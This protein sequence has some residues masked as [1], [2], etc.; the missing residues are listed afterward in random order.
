MHSSNMFWFAEYAETD[1]WWAEFARAGSEW[2]SE[3][4]RAGPLAGGAS[5]S[6]EVP[7]AALNIPCSAGGAS[8]SE[9][10]PCDHSS[11]EYFLLGSHVPQA[12]LSDDEVP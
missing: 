2:D 4:A 1:P 8:A 10:V 5:A 6:E 12:V 9:D 3:F 7:C 11:D